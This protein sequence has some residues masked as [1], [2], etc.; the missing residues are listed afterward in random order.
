MSVKAAWVPVLPEMKD[1]AST[2]VKEVATASRKAGTEGGNALTKAMDAATRADAADKMVADLKKASQQ[3]SRAV[4]QSTADI[5]RARASE[6]DAAAKVTL[7]EQKLADA[8]T[9]YGSNSAQATAAEQKLEAA[10]ERQQVAAGKVESA[11]GTLKSAKEQQ[12]TV[13]GQLT[14]AE[15]KLATAQK[16]VSDSNNSHLSTWDKV[17]SKVSGASGVLGGLKTGLKNA[18]IAFGMV[19]A[20]VATATA[21]VS[22]AVKPYEDWGKQ[23]LATRRLIGG[24]SEDASRLAFSLKQ[25]GVAADA[26]QVSL[27]T[28]AKFVTAAGSSSSKAA[29]LTSLMGNSWKD[30]SGKAKSMQDIMPQLAD[31]FAKMPDGAQKTALAVQLFGKNGTAMIPFLDKGSKGIAELN[32]QSD[33]L[34]MTLGD[35]DV[36]AAV[37]STVAKR[38]LTAQVDALKVGLGKNLMPVMLKGVDIIQNRVIPGAQALMGGMEK[39]KGLIVTLGSVLLGLVVGIKA[40]IVVQQI[41]NAVSTANPIGLIIVGVAALVAGIVLFFTK[42]EAGRKILS[43]VWSGIKSFVAWVGPAWSALWNGVGQVFSTVWHAIRDNWKVIIG[44]IAA[45]LLGGPIVGALVVLFQKNKAFHDSVVG[46]WNAIKS[47]ISSAIAWIGPAWSGLWNGAGELWSKFWRGIVSGIT[48]FGA[49]VRD[50]WNGLWNGV[51][52]LWSDFWHGVATGWN[53]MWSKIGSVISSAGALLKTAWHAIWSWVANIASTFWANEVRGFTRLK[54][55]VVNAFT[56]LK[57]KSIDLVEK[58]R[59]G[60]GKAWSGLKKLAADPIN[61]VIREVYTGGLKRLADNIFEKL[62]MKTRLPAIS[63]VKLAGGGVIP[64]YEPGVDTVHAV[65]SKGEA[66]LVPELTRAIGPANILAANAAASGR[67]SA[68]GA[69]F[70]GGGIAGALSNIGGFFKDKWEGLGA[71]IGNIASGV[72]DLIASPVKALFSLIPGGIFG[73]IGKGV[74]STA[75]GGLTGFF[76]KETSGLAGSGGL[77]GAAMRAVSARV[78]YVWGGS[79]VPPGLDCSGLVYW[80]AQQ[81]GWGW[82]RLT[83]AGYQSASRGVSRA[84]AGPGSLLFWGHPA[85]H[86]AVNAG[87]GMMVEEP[88]PGA[89][90]RYVPIWGAPSAGV[91]SGGHSAGTYESL[92]KNAATSLGGYATVGSLQ[93][94]LYSAQYDSGG[95]VM[96]GITNV[97]N[98]SNKPEA[99]LTNAQSK[100]LQRIAGS[101]VSGPSEVRAVFSPD[102]VRVLAAAVREGADAGVSGRIGSAERVNVRALRGVH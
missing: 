94:R 101:T 61:F 76:K 35:K 93:N 46:V 92:I 87:N 36:K 83:A 70:A 69:R 80:A 30:A 51:G 4:Q 86:V 25:S 19:T 40:V 56:T 81:L 12:K 75:L 100:N 98:A 18:S 20:G 23:V 49:G 84:S 8:R 21:A 26:S 52:K 5:G 29:T 28:L 37:A 79:S 53:N 22:S 14:D 66:V 64:G 43:T 45:F 85:Y 71:F 16:S 54:D 91:Y 13:T 50:L 6:R 74:I 82:P 77:V 47:G 24:S 9:K 96:P 55:N 97:I 59:D 48:S 32:A 44:D 39:H 89:V 15:N 62:G 99:V 3:A 73:D 34:G 63:E 41:W 10:R 60:I 38:K 2:L 65:L 67:P 27:K 33:K 68:N 72:K 17:K 88:H 1:F 57:T 58:M 7:A 95:W 31:S 42:T 78:P 90:A 102:Q 11:E